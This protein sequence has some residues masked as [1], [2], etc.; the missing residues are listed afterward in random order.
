MKHLIGQK[1]P[2]WE[3]PIL[4][5]IPAPVSDKFT[6][7]MEIYGKTG[8]FTKAIPVAKSNQFDIILIFRTPQLHGSLIYEWY[9]F[10]YT[11]GGRSKYY[12]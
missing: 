4:Q 6:K 7:Y 10:F 12:N 1:A 9:S 3:S 2:K 8:D 5:I 11:E